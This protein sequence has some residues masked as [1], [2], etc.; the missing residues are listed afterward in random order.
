MGERIY[1]DHL[2]VAPPLPEVLNAISMCFHQGATSANSLH[3]EGLQARRVWESACEKTAN[4]LGARSPEDILFTSSSNEALN[5]AL[6]GAVRAS[7]QAR[8]HILLSS[9]EH[10]SLRGAAAQLASEGVEVS[11]LPV[12]H[13]GLVDPLMLQRMLKPET[14]LVAVHHANHDTGA[15]Q[16]IAAI[17]RTLEN[18][19]AALLVDATASNGWS[20]VSAESLGATLLV[21]SPIKFH[22]PSGLGILYRR[23]GLTLRSIL[24]TGENTPLGDVFPENVAA[25]AGLVALLESW[26]EHGQRWRAET[27]ALQSSLW[28]RLTTGV[29]GLHLHGPP[30]GCLRLPHNL[31]FSVENLEGE[32]LAL[33]MDLKGYAIGS[34]AACLGR[35]QAMPHNLAAMGVPR[36]L[37][38]RNLLV[39]LG[40]LSTPHQI[41]AFAQQ[42][43]ATIER[44]RTLLR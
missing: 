31:N 15:I 29:S 32:G 39:G 12:D 9:T 8:R 18:H 33:A 1:L 23:R 26:E 36:D 38:K 37:G 4:F 35:K 22:G 20:E 43:I 27:H 11:T 14:V 16:P 25:A 28:S 2:T 41:D 40:V 5:L 44:Q 17:A 7:D 24:H 30:P 10:P 19:T 13:H 3:R 6:L 21:L 42:L 34:G